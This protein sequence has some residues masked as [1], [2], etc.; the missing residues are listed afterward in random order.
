[1][2]LWSEFNFENEA[3]GPWI[4]SNQMG[5]RT[6]SKDDPLNSLKSG[7]RD[8]RVFSNV[9]SVETV[10]KFEHATF[11]QIKLIVLGYSNQMVKS[12]KSKDNGLSS[13][14]AFHDFRV[15]S[16]AYSTKTYEKLNMALWSESH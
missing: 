3:D 12:P 10:Q 14:S 16:N 8:F 15:F 5:K 11:E 1:M 6:A 9:N 13:K 4:R 2:P 7:V